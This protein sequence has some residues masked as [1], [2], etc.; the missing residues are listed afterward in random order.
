MQ[1]RMSISGGASADRLSQN[2]TFTGRAGYVLSL[3]NTL[4]T[5]QFHF[6]ITARVSFSNNYADGA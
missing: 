2:G 4:V 5:R 1:D 3:E 6:G